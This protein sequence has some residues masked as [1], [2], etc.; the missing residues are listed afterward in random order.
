MQFPH[1]VLL[2]EDKIEENNYQ[3]SRLLKLPDKEI[4]YNEIV[5][6]YELLI[7]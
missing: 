2:T 3:F 1:D 7:K 6:A 4:K 5:I